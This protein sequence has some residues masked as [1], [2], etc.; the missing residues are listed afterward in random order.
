M[1]NKISFK[2]TQN[3][4]FIIEFNLEVGESLEMAKSRICGSNTFLWLF[5]SKN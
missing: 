2:D 4:E 5:Y 3:T 1:T